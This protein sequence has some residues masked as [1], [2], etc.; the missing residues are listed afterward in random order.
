MEI[1]NE[2]GAIDFAKRFQR[3]QGRTGRTFNTNAKVTKEEQTELESAARADG[4]ALGE[5][6]REVL[7]KAARGAITDPAFTEIIAMRRLLNSVLRHVACGERMTPEAF[8]AEMQEIRKT[9]HK[10]AA[11][12]MQQYATTEATRDE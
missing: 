3:S 9:K 4:K 5:W 11:E 10:A 8:N 6:S 1:G 12:I 7:L 2:P